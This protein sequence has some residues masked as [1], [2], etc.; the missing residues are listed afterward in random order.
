MFLQIQRGDFLPSGLKDV[1]QSLFFKINA[2]WHNSFFD[3]VLPFV[4]EPTVWVPFYFFL[5][6]FVLINFKSDGWLWILFLML[7]AMITDYTSSSIIKE[8]F[9][10]LRPCRD[11]EI[12]HRVRFLVAYCPISSSFV[13]SHAVNH[14]AISTFIF[15]TFKNA[16]SRKWILVYIW[17]FAICYAQVYVGV[18]FPL[19]VTAGAIIGTILGYITSSVFNRFFP[20]P[21]FTL[22][23]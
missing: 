19:D 10:R 14:F 1:D 2:Q 9:P 11:P 6:I 18:H 13:S 12:A 15:V 7:T 3:A 5:S 21:D 22:K 8:W 17:A 16:I 23:N 4:R 20:L